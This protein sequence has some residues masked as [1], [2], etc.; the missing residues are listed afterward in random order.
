GTAWLQ[1]R[2]RRD[3]HE[4]PGEL[5]GIM[6]EAAR[7]VR[8]GSPPRLRETALVE[9]PA[10]FGLFRPCLLLPHGFA[11][12]LEPH[13]IRHVL[14]HEAAHLK[15]RDLVVNWLMALAQAIHWFNP[16]VWLAFRQ[17]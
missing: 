10:V 7:A 15:R 17:M 13:E 8:L 12:R 5:K 16:L 9:S 1:W 11:E 14:L 4:S 2:L 3:S 6:E